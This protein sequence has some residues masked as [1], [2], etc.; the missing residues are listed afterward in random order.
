MIRAVWS[1]FMKQSSSDHPRYTQPCLVGIVKTLVSACPDLLEEE[2]VVTWFKSHLSDEYCSLFQLACKQE[3]LIPSLS[4]PSTCPLFIQCIQLLTQKEKCESFLTTYYDRILGSQPFRCD[5]NK[6]RESHAVL[7]YVARY[8]QN[9]MS[10]T[11]A[12]SFFTRVLQLARR[13]ESTREEILQEFN[14]CI[15]TLLQFIPFLAIVEPICENVEG[16]I[17][18]AIVQTVRMSLNLY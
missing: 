9:Q 1:F 3:R 14:Q 17:K 8:L 6:P 4:I 5:C 16:V 15:L 10:F 18:K 11:F 13:P 12:Y 2:E 7:L